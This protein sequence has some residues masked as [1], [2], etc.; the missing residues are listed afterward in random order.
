MPRQL[1]FDLPARPAL[2]R[3]DFLIAPSN[4]VALTVLDSTWPQG[5]LALTGPEG[6]G[7]SHLAQVW[8]AEQGA[9]V[10]QGQALATVALG[11]INPAAVVVD[12][13]DCIAGDP[14]AEQALFHLHNLVLA[15]GGLLLLTG[16][17]APARWGV[18]LPDLASR[19]AA[20]ATA[21]LEP[22]DDL[23][24]STLLVKLFADRQLRVAP[25][26]IAYLVARMDRSFAAAGAL[27]AALDARAL[28]ERRAVNR[29]LA[30]E[31]L[32]MALKRQP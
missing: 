5:K 8:A 11:Q 26:L 16:V 4:R 28:A 27:V 20:T 29:G 2:G 13:A 6:A 19:L 31:V 22:P 25:D 9:V 21:A 10:L 17:S 18:A 15:S 12:D 23:L 30:A 24:L 14:T 32:D 1:T 3:G 7:K